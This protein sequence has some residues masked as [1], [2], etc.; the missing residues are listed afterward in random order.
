L[1]P[2]HHSTLGMAR[3]FSFENKNIQKTKFLFETEY[4]EENSVNPLKS[5]QNFLK[6]KKYFR[7]HF[8]S[9]SGRLKIP[10]KLKIEKISFF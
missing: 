7:T 5:L 10:F 3:F 1:R 2:E 6:K 9:S 8:E 4:P